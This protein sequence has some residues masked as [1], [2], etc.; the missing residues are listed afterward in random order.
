M[1]CPV[2]GTTR[3]TGVPVLVTV[4]VSPRAAEARI[5]E[6]FWLNSRVVVSM[7]YM[8][9]HLERVDASRR[10]PHGADVCRGHGRSSSPRSAGQ[11]A[12]ADDGIPSFAAIEV[13]ATDEN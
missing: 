8:L 1:S 7:F 13:T 12:P 11:G 5:C 9:L 2:I 3:A 6:D 10:E 4:T